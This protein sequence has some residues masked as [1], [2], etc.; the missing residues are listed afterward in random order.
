MTALGPGVRVYIGW[1][2]KVSPM[3]AHTRCHTGTLLTGPHLP[4]DTFTTS[5]GEMGINIDPFTVWEV[6]PDNYEK[7]VL[8]AEKLLYPIDDWDEPIEEDIEEPECTE[9]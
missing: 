4:H 8:A 7:T 9:A 6:K 3:V 2:T 5:Y 1:T